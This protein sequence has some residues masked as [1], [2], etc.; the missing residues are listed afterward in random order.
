MEAKEIGME[1]PEVTTVSVMGEE[2][3]DIAEQLPNSD[4]GAF[5]E[6]TTVTVGNMTA[7]DNVFTTSVANASISEHVLS[8]RTTLQ[9]GEGLPTDKATLIVVHTDGSIVETTGLKAPSTPVTPGPQ[10]PSTPLTLGP[11]KD[12]TK[13][14]WDPSVYENELPVRCRNISGILYKNKLGSGGRGR[15]IKNGETWFTPT[16]F[17]GIAGRAS[18]KDWKRSI[19]YAGRPL[20]C[21][22]Q[23]GILNPHAASCTCAACCDD[24]SLVERLTIAVLS[25]SGGWERAKLSLPGSAH[26]SAP[27]GSQSRGDT[28]NS[29]GEVCGVDLPAE[30]TWVKEDGK[31][32]TG[33]FVLSAQTGPVRLFVPYKRRK[34]ENEQTV[35]PVKKES[36]KNITLLPATPGTTF[37]MT[38]AGQI[39]G[40]AALTFDR[41]SSGDT[42]AIISNSTAPGD[43]FTGTTVTMTPAGQITG[44]AALTFDRSSSGDTTTII[45]NSTA[46]GDVFT[47]TTVLASLPALGVPT[48]CTPTKAPSPGT[49]N[50]LEVAEGRSWL[51]L[52]ETANS[53]MAMAQQLKTLIEQNLNQYQNQM[54]L[55]QGEDADGKTEIIIKQ[56]CINCGREAMNECTGCHK[57]HYCSTFCQRKDWKDHQHMCG[58]PTT[59]TVQ[60]E[61]VQVTE[62]DL[63]KVKV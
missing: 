16:E 29:C 62:V 43:V 20:Q 49:L 32:V 36:P 12:G 4:E 60:A 58:Q 41:S 55:H 48:P 23:D 6:V 30:G 34:K 37:T 56:T 9:I 3:L 10:T 46:P 18:S 61:D 21:L 7:A 45:S 50:G 33:A 5:A 15:C 2:Q 28:V 17:E 27:T 19:R 26:C 40:S 38:P 25:K 53:L 24:M 22:I 31:R 44:S 8:G 39:T 11:E 35:T 54:P 52:E 51:Y 63:E 59:L 57:V 47:G 14:H 1:S 13:Y 42:T